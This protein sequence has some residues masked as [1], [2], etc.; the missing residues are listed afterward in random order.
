MSKARPTEP[1]PIPGCHR[2]T[3]AARGIPVCGE[4]AREISLSVTGPSRRR[5]LD[6]ETD[7][8]SLRRII[9]R[10]T[11]QLRAFQGGE[12]P[13]PE[14]V[15]R[16]TDGVVYYL[17]SGAYIK[18]GWSADLEKRMRAYTPDSILLAVEPGDR[19]LETRRHRMFAAHRTH[20]R[21]W[22]AMV[23]ALLHHI[24]TIVTA[25]GTPDPVTFAA[26]PVTIPQPRPKTYV[27]GNY[28]GKGLV[29]LGRIPIPPLAQ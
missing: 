9:Q 25:H 26:K 21:E 16:P 15:K 5:E 3:W 13:T 7:I 6:L 27:G 1:C 20:G 2:R 19:M 18:I 29:G 10:Q 28:R 4:C 12:V 23:P 22:Y 8:L 17:R 24:E 11:Q 14:K